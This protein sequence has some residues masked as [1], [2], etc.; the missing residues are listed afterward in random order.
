MT[1]GYRIPM[2]GKK[3]GRLT[4]GAFSH[5]S[6]HGD[7]MYDCACSCGGT[8]TTAGSTLRDGRARSCGCSRADSKRRHGHTTKTTMTTEY[9]AWH[10]MRQRCGN[11]KNKRF[12]SYGGR[13]ITVCERWETFDLFF[14]DMGNRPKGKSLDRKNNDEGYSPE[15]CRW[16]TRF[17]QAQNTQRT[18]LSM[19][20]ARDIRTKRASGVR[21]RDLATEYGVSKS[22]ILEVLRQS[23]WRETE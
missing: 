4:V 7:A 6:S 10:A 1:G 22:A 21:A 3:I 20:K 2:E 12:P 13:G 5:I 19:E 23:T 15:N 11:P 8:I 17:E 14:A 9:K 18:K 16:A